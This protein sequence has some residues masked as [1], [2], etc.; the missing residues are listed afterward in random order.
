MGVPI[1][2]TPKQATYLEII[3]PELCD[4]LETTAKSIFKGIP[5]IIKQISPI[6]ND[7]TSVKD[8]ENE[9]EREHKKIIEQ[10][11]DFII[12]FEK[13]MKRMPVLYEIN[14]NLDEIVNQEII[15]EI[16]NE[17]I[18]S[19]STSLYDEYEA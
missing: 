10:I 4:S 2:L 12:K 17:I 14:D 11:K 13:E 1:N 7:N 3:K 15:K 6:N 5:T 18:L 16:L 9:Q 19:R 8:K